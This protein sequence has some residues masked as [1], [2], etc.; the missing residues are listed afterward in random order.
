MSGIVGIVQFDE[1]PVD[2]GLLRKLTD[3]LVFR[4]PDG[5]QTWIKDNVGFAHT[6]FRTTEES[7]RDSQPLT[8]DGKTWIVADARIDAQQELVAALKDAG[9][10]GIVPSRWTDAE[11]ILRAYRAWGPDCV[12]HLL[13]DFAFG[14]WDDARQRLFCAR[15][16]MGVKPFYYAQLGAYVIFSNTLDCIRQD[17]RISARLND[18]A[19]A[20]FLLFGF[21]Q[22]PATTSFAEIRRIPPA[23]CATWSRDDFGIR[24]YWSMPIEEPIFYKQANDYI[25]HF[26]DLL[27]K[28][29]AD[30]LRTNRLGVFMSGGIDSPTLAST[31]RDLLRQHHQSFELLAL[32][33][34][35][36]LLPEE[37]HYAGIVASHLGIP[38]E[39][40]DWNNIEHFNW[41]QTSFSLPEPRSDAYLILAERR[42]WN[43]LGG[44]SRVFFY[45]EG[46]DNA[47]LLD[48]QSYIHYLLRHGQYTLL[49]R[50]ILTTLLSEKRL[51]FWQRI[52]NKIKGAGRLP[53]QRE[54]TYPGWLNPSFEARLQLR[55]RWHTLHAP[56]LSPHPVRPKAYASFQT[57][58]WQLLFEHFDTGVTK[59][60]FD[61]RH[62]FLDVR[63]LRF[64]LALPALPWCRS[65]YLIRRAMRERL[66]NEILA[67]RKATI[68]SRRTGSFFED[69]C[70]TPFRPNLELC[71]FIDPHRIS[72]AQ[73]GGVESQ[74]R[75]RS[76]N[77]WLQNS[78]RN[79]HTFVESC[80]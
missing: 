29:I 28:S 57:P 79:S 38:V 52:S 55:E 22:E 48:W 43:Q 9:E 14:I 62:P 30:R 72:Q 4:G 63:M 2:S 12:E 7:E 19:I 71:D 60:A 31:A 20:D 1:S 3:F 66:P 8:L 21:N 47:L 70:T 10:V 6:L 69:S 41:E 11:L 37:R 80:S 54:E 24:R 61:V 68:N 16:H 15:D 56:G 36:S 25:A 33:N 64:L 45:G 32:T 40:R 53:N 73:P 27:H 49:A 67:R 5:Q 65:K 59:L 46:P 42:F 13:G 77:H 35:D 74:L 75:I 58:L 76:L 34:V 44:Y 50:D 51:P 17:P 23:H 39:Y 26:H 78:C 18:L